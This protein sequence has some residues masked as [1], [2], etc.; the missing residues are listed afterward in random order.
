MIHPPDDVRRRAFEIAAL[1]RA[2]QPD[3]D[4]NMVIVRETSFLIAAPAMEIEQLRSGT[5]STLRYALRLG[6]PIH[7]L[8][9]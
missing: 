6:R 4:R 8:T 9:P 3:L 1:N 2:P 7:L 5:W